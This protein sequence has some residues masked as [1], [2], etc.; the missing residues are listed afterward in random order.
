MSSNGFGINNKSRYLFFFG[1]KSINGYLSNWYMAKFT[2][3]DSGLVF[4]N[5]EQ[6]MMWAKANLFG[7]EDIAAKILRN[8]NPALCKK[9]GRQVRKFHPMIWSNRCIDIVT[10]ACYYK[11]SQNPNLKQLLLMTNDRIL[12]EASP[13]DRIWGIGYTT[14]DAFKVEKNKW[15]QNL[16]GKC[17]MKVRDSF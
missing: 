5:T 17:L 15:G 2:D 11:F 10:K 4:E 16:L 3:P 8:P 13:Y 1:E 9:L 14:W 7:D 12:V 6:Y